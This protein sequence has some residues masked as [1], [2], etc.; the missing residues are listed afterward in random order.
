[1]AAIRLGHVC[2]HVCVCAMCMC[3]CSDV[4]LIIPHYVQAQTGAVMPINGSNK[5]WTGMC[6]CTVCKCVCALCACVCVV[7]FF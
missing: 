1:M 5:T 7:M 6:V 4:F 3:V 2:V